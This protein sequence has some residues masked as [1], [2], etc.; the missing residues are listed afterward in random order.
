VGL[1]G[2]VGRVGVDRAA[3]GQPSRCSWYFSHLLR[4]TFYPQFWVFLLSRF[5]VY[6]GWLVFPH[7]I[8]GRAQHPRLCEARPTD[9][10]V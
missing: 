5:T 3:A 8:Y 4:S 9:T 2:I 7:N 6:G 10:E 1:E